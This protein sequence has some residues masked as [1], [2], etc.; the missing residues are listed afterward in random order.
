[1]GVPFVDEIDQRVDL[2]LADACFQGR[3]AAQARGGG[4]RIGVVG[5]VVDDLLHAARGGDV[6]IQQVQQRLGLFGGL[7]GVT[8]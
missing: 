6:E 1:M 4:H 7:L 5:A 3:A 2:G 8:L